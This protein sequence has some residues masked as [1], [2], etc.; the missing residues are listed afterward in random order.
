MVGAMLKKILSGI[1][2]V[3]SALWTALSHFST[4]ITMPGDIQHFWD[5]YMGGTPMIAWMVFVLASALALWVYLP[6]IQRWVGG[7]PVTAEKKMLNQSVNIGTMTGGNVSPS[8][9]N[10]FNTIVALHRSELSE[11]GMDQLAKA[12]SGRVVQVDVVGD[13]KCLMIGQ[14]L[15]SVLSARGITFGNI[16]SIGVMGP[17]PSEPY[18]VIL[19]PDGQS[20]KLVISPATL[21]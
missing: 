3:L 15:I 7:K 4:A 5:S 8:Y 14:K 13:Q 11:E 16:R 17:P 20:A 10:N 12:L 2:W 9:V 21:P 18:S 6:L 1:F 19:S